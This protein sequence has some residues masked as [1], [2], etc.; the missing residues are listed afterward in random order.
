MADA[1]K[2][3]AQAVKDK[4]SGNLVDF[5]V[6]LTVFVQKLHQEPVMKQTKPQRKTPV[7]RLVIV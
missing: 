4:A 6:N 5:H 2:K 1:V 7:N 3:G